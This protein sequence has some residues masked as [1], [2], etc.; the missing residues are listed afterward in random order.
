MAKCAL[1]CGSHGICQSVYGLHA[2]ANRPWKMLDCQCFFF[3]FTMNQYCHFMYQWY[4]EN[5]AFLGASF[6]L[7]RFVL[8]AEKK[9]SL[10][11]RIEWLLL[12]FFSKM[13]AKCKRKCQE[14]PKCKN[15]GKHKVK[16]PG[17]QWSSADRGWL[18]S[19]PSFRKHAFVRV[20]LGNSLFL[21]VRSHWFGKFWQTKQNP[22]A[23]RPR[24]N[25][26][27]CR[28]ANAFISRQDS[29]QNFSLL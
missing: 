19:S 7:E 6:I 26:H 12:Q 13:R 11:L 16:R 17:Y 10:L 21:V 25:L 23:A 8:K 29:D 28:G 5:C 9:V 4:G 2:G 20:D 14:H 27:V 1:P 22:V 18:T 3:F 15:N 24:K